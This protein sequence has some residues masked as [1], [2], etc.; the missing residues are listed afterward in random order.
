MAHCLDLRHTYGVQSRYR[1]DLRGILDGQQS[2]EALPLLLS[3]VFAHCADDY[4]KYCE[5]EKAEEAANNYDLELLMEEVSVLRIAL[6]SG[7]PV[8][9]RFASFLL[10]RNLSKATALFDRQQPCPA[11]S[12]PYQTTRYMLRV[13]HA[14]S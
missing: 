4:D 12:I 2:P 13:S 5:P 10:A 11:T 8:S 3:F 6:T 7:L 9:L 14:K 1:H